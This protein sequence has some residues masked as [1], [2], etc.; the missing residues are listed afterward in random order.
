MRERFLSSELRDATPFSKRRSTALRPAETISFVS[1]RYQ[2][3]TSH[4]SKLYPYYVHQGKNRVASLPNIRPCFSLLASSVLI[5][6]R[7]S[8][9]SPL[10]SSRKH[11]LL[12][13]P[14]PEVLSSLEGSPVRLLH[15]SA[16]GTYVPNS[17]YL[18]PS[19]STPSNQLIK[20]PHM[21]HDA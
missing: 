21:N 17:F 4:T 2:Y 14:A 8:P 18:S 19:L 1:N 12:H 20:H 6:R 5:P 9:H 7:H 10:T 3:H 15:A 16:L 11:D 13:S